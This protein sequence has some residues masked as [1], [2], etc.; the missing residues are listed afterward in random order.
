MK[1]EIANAVQKEFED[2]VKK[3]IKRVSDPSRKSESQLKKYF[4]RKVN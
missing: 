4:F 1:K 3:T 2:C